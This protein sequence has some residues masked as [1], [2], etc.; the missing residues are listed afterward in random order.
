L[1]MLFELPTI[2]MLSARLMA[3]PEW[4][5][6][7]EQVSRLYRELENLSEGEIDSLLHGD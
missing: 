2:A 1:R 5:F 4:R 3:S 7:I 6:Q